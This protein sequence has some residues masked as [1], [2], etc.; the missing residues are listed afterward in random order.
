MKCQQHLELK[1]DA[2]NT[3]RDQVSKSERCKK[4]ELS[5]LSR[6]A[7][8]NAHCLYMFSVS[9]ISI[10]ILVGEAKG[11]FNVAGNLT[12]PKQMVISQFR[13]TFQNRKNKQL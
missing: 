6:T 12:S 1:S 13:Y 9:R 5:K 8:Q 11:R 10:Q 2:G 4:L 7:S 3:A